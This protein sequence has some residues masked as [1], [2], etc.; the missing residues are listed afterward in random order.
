MDTLTVYNEGLV[1]FVGA[2]IV[3]RS[4][5]MST[6][7][8]P[9]CEKT[10][11]PNSIKWLSREAFDTLV[12]ICDTMLPSIDPNELTES[13]VSSALKTLFPGRDATDVEFIQI[14]SIQKN[15]EFF[16]RGALSCGIPLR[17]IGLL[18]RDCTLEQ[19]QGISVLLSMLGSP[20]GT[21]FMTGY[22]ASFHA[23][24]LKNRTRAICIL[25]NSKIQ[26]LRS[27]FQVGYMYTFRKYQSNGLLHRTSC[28]LPAC[29]PA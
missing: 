26:L 1:A 29:L 14:D 10:M 15:G 21:L 11:R 17:L 25:R 3:S 2:L 4:Y 5:L 22:V 28:P 12:A 6:S 27:F 23:M 16:K 19:R 9:R 20:L 18:E 8:G 13:E 7:A 24:S